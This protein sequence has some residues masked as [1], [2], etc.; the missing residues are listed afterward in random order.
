MDIRNATREDL[1][2][3]HRLIERAYRGETARRGWTHEADLL[4]GQRTDP[5]SL[6]AALTD[7]TRQVILAESAGAIIGS[8]TV[9]NRGHG[10]AYLGMLAVDPDRQGSGVGSLLVAEAERRAKA[11]WEADTIEMT[12]IGL[13]TELIDY[14]K[15]RGYFL[16]DEVR[17]F[18]L[19]D[20][21]YG[22]PRRRDLDFNVL[23]KPLRPAT[24]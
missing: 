16:T 23:A 12:V 13:R 3:L 6:T 5:E 22:I 14:Y 24:L 7:L 10:L 2:A 9:E 20:P 19:D 8:V 17:P 15:R 21:K 4:G 11:K 18:P 1:P